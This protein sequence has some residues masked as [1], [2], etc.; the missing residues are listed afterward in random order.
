MTLITDGTAI[1]IQKANPDMQ[2]FLF[3]NQCVIRDSFF[4][5]G[6]AYYFHGKIWR[7]PTAQEFTVK[8]TNRDRYQDL[9][10]SNQY[11]RAFTVNNIKPES[12][13][14]EDR[15]YDFEFIFVPFVEGYN[16][17]VFELT[18]DTIDLS[19]DTTRVPIICFEE[20]SEINNKITSLITSENEVE[21]V[22]LGIQGRPNS[23]LCLNQEDIRIP[24]SGIQELKEGSIAIDFISFV[25]PAKENTS[26]M[27]NQMDSVERDP[28]AQT[29]VSRCFFGEDKVRP[30]KAFAVDFIYNVN[31]S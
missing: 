1:E 27:Q 13:I 23:I 11:I 25:S 5:T 20:L 24:R 17:I 26:A 14:L 12:D 31:E 18:R 2:G 6:T 15:Q 10:F 8:L 19:P 21:I 9:D 22:K 3:K 30:I 7:L 16:T 4:K 29:S 28:H